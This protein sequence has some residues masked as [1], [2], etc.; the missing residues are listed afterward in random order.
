MLHF[1]RL[2][3]TENSIK[4][5]IVGLSSTF[6]TKAFDVTSWR[7]FDKKRNSFVQ[8]PGNRLHG[9]VNAYYS[10]NRVKEWTVKDIKRETSFYN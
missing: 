1:S 2:I 3:I 4:N 5:A 9:I 10:L 6:Y 7:V 8:Y